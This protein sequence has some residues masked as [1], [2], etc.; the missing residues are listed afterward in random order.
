MPKLTLREFTELFR[1][2]RRDHPGRTTSRQDWPASQR[3]GHKTQ[4]SP[5]AAAHRGCDAQRNL[6]GYVL[7]LE[8]MR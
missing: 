5:R 7:R 6:R 4:A 8:L 2:P 1:H 3:P